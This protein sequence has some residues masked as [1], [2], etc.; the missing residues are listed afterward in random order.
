LEENGQLHAQAALLAGKEAPVTI[1]KEVG[2]AEVPIWKA[3]R[4]E[5]PCFYRD[6]NCDPSAVQFVAS[7]YTDCSI[8][9]LKRCSTLELMGLVGLDVFILE[10]FNYDVIKKEKIGQ[11]AR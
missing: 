1:G 8:P 7:R 2:W 6:S 10:L 5:K 9:A 4:R 11:E 3:W